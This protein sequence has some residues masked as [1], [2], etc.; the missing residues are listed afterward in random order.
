MLR[1]LRRLW[2]ASFRRACP[3]EAVRLLLLVEPCQHQSL[4]ILPEKRLVRSHDLGNYTTYPI[5][6]PDAVE[7]VAGIAATKA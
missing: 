3:G 7:P 1:C 6:F 4:Q 5:Y 2:R